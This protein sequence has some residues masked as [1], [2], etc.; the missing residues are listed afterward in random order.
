MV[1]HVRGELSLDDAVALIKTRTRQL[2]KRQLTWF[3][4]EP[5]LEWVEIG[6]DEPPTD[7][8]TR[9]RGIAQQREKNSVS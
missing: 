6:R 3:R 2:A 8:V 5:Q 1:A 9:V 7:T 4:R